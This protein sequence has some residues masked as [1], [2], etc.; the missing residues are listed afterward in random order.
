VTSG[1]DVAIELDHVFICVA[2]GAPEAGELVQFGLREGTPN[3]HA[4]QGT[5]NRRFFFRNAM[6]ELLWVENPQE[7]QSEQT[8]PTQLWERWSRRQ[9]GACPFGIIVRPP[10]NEPTPVPF[11]SQEY[12]PIWLQPDLRIYFAPVGL[13][14]PLP[15]F[16]PFLQRIRYGQQFV[17]HPNG[18][19]EIT[20]MTLTTPGPLRSLAA[21]TLIESAVFTSRTGPEYLLTIELDHGLRQ[22]E[23]DFRPDLPL[24]IQR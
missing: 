20:G 24:V 18:A 12:R 8:A 6:L 11:P 15:F 1:T 22:E 4:G 19:R 9:T 13:K 14:E 10:N 21:Q 2:R 3:V 17:A 16:M 5:A 23:K 7:T